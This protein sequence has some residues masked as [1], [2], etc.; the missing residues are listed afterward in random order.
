V[1]DT[2]QYHPL[3]LGSRRRQRTIRIIVY[4]LLTLT[5]LLY[6]LPLFIVL[7]NSFRDL[8]EINR[9]SLIGWPQSFSLD[10]WGKAW[11]E[12]QIGGNGGG[13]SPYFINSFLM[14][15]PA[16]LIS[17]AL[18][19]IN[20]YALSIWRFPGHKWVFGIMLFG[21]FVPGQL[22]LLP[23]AMI[24]GTIKLSNSWMGLVVVHVVFGIG[25]VTLFFRNFYVQ[26]PDEIIR[27]AR[28]D[29]AGFW[30][31][32]WRIILPLSPP[33]IIVTIIWEFTHAWNEYLY[34]STFT[35][36]YNR[37]IT[38]ALIA[39]SGTNQVAPEYNIQSAAV[40]IAALPTLAIYLFGGRYFLRGLAAGAVKG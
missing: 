17:T 12:V 26:I 6:V 23:W 4:T 10:A 29:G 35:S 1:T 11:G 7:L 36:G 9:T 19:A 32:F 27:A 40:I 39:I 25:F 5:A 38:A 34:A 3:Q 16:T 31:I 15:V 22:M 24:L 37:P 30:R 20:G 33:I 2:Y 13:I 18:G 21:V 8:Q 28:I 14:V